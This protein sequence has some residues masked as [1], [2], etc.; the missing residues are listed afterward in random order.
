MSKP[1]IALALGLA[2][3]ACAAPTPYAP[4]GKPHVGHVAK[5]YADEQVV[6]DR[7]RVSFAGNWVTP[8]ATVE[9][10]VYY[11]AAQVTLQ[12]GHDFFRVVERELDHRVIHDAVADFFPGYGF[13]LTGFIVVYPGHTF[14]VAATIEVAHGEA[15]ADEADAF[16]ARR[17]LKDLAP[18]VGL[19]GDRSL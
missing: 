2:L 7:Y 15:P 13:G 10:Y 18:H 3:A 6:P 4:A 8:L 11:R 12:S 14:A 16:D 5:G 1:W 17:V 19:S 9:G